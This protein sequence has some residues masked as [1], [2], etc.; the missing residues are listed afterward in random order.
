MAAAVSPHLLLR[1]TGGKPR[2]TQHPSWPCWGPRGAGP[3]VG[4]R[5]GL[6]GG[7][8]RGGGCAGVGARGQSLSAPRRKQPPAP[9]SREQPGTNSSWKFPQS[10]S[11]GAW[12][13]EQ[14]CREGESCTW[15]LD[16][17]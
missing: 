13:G 7:E 12:G 10:V 14:V 3:E 17:L 6:G 1:G 16:Q 9:T 15:G 4:C 8:A 11:Q 5:E 2:L